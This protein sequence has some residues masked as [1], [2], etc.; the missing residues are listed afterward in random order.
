MQSNAE[1]PTATATYPPF[2]QCLAS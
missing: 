1:T 2:M